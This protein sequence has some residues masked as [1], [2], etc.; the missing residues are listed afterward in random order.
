MPSEN[1]FEQVS[2]SMH[3]NAF[4]RDLPPK[5]EKTTIQAN[6]ETILDNEA[7]KQQPLLLHYLF[8]Q[9]LNTEDPHLIASLKSAYETLPEKNPILLQ[10]AEGFLKKN[11]GHYRQAVNIYQRLNQSHP[12]DERI[13]LDTAAVLFEDKQWTEADMLFAQTAL[14]DD[15]P[16]AVRHNIRRYRDKIREHNTWQFNGSLSMSR[17]GNIND[18]APAYCSPIGCQPSQKESGTGINYGLNIEKNTP[19]SGHHNLYFRSYTGGTSYYFD[20]KS[21][22]DHTLHR[23][24]LGWQYQNARN[25]LNILPFYQ[26]QLAGSDEFE[27]K[28]KNNH[29]LIPNMLAHALGVQITGTHRLPQN[30]GQI[31]INAESYRQHYRP[32]EKQPL[33][34]GN[35]YSLSL[36]LAKPAGRHHL[37]FIGLGSN[38]FL[39]RQPQLNGRSNHTAYTRSFIHTGWLAEWPSLAG[40]QSRL[41]AQYGQRRY[42]GQALDT[43]FFYRTQKNYETVFSASISH[44]K[45]SYR[46]LTPK[47]TWEARKTRSTHKWAER[48]QQQLFVEIEK[49]F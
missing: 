17:N 12:Q 24:H 44:P 25:T 48:S 18:A 10:R 21:Q 39:P 6:V 27:S 38:W 9:S 11:A 45:L 22:Y 29:R 5:D 41:S 47:L 34:D 2:D 20:K 16:E 14:S 37:L 23:S 31:Q 13:A 30:K 26:A 7:L 32:K 15:L 46:G 8:E 40:L 3:Q 4:I 1:R 19:L 42:K 43:D 33:Y 36:S 35:H 28:P 49:N